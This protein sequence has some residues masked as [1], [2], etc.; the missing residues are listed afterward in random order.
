[1][2]KEKPNFPGQR[3]FYFLS[4]LGLIPGFGTIVSVVIIFYAIFRLKNIGLLILAFLIMVIG[5]VMGVINH[6]YLMNDIKFGENTG[7]RFSIFVA[8]DLDTIAKKLEQYK[9]IL[10]VYPDSLEELKK[11]YPEISIVDMLLSR[12]SHAHKSINFYY[13]RRGD[14]YILYSSGVDGI[15]N[16]PDD[17]YPRRP[18]SHQNQTDK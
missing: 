8:D 14:K 9:S 1:M 10:G 18:L 11:N 2:S 17:I 12:N 16:T 6:N 4:L 5:I 15:P 13:H 3:K 7:K